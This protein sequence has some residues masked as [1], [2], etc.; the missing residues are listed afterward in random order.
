MRTARS[1]LAAVVLMSLVA[2]RV[3]ATCPEARYTI[4][5]SVVD[6]LHKPVSGVRVLLFADDSSSALAPEAKLPLTAPDGTFT[7]ELSYPTLARSYSRATSRD[8]SRRLR[9]LDIVVVSS[10]THYPIHKRL[11]LK[12]QVRQVAVL[13]YSVILDPVVL[14]KRDFD[15]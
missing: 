9:K 8:C 10:P 6:D 12:R 4:K 1:L 14:I 7:F 13:D 3:A 15:R 11:K 2:Q 5:G